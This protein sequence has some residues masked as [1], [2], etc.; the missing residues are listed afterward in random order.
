M[1]YI[2]RKD[3]IHS[4]RISFGLFVNFWSGILERFD[5]QNYHNQFSIVSILLLMFCLY[6]LYIFNNFSDCNVSYDDFITLATCSSCVTCWSTSIARLFILSFLPILFSASF[7]F[8]TTEYVSALSRWWYRL[9]CLVE[10][11]RGLSFRSI[12]NQTIHIRP[13]F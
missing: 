4:R 13:G 1:Y 6:G 10:Q 3:S 2:L 11:N 7:P 5:K 9:T 8:N 12:K